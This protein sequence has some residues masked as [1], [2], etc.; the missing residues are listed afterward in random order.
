M[1]K[2]PISRWLAGYVRG[3]AWRVAV[4]RHPM[5]Y[6]N[7]AME[8]VQ[9]FASKADLNVAHCTI[10]EREEYEPHIACGNVIFA[11]VDYAAVLRAAEAEADILVWDGGNND[12]PFIRP[13][14][15]I[16][17][18]DALR[19]NQVATHYPGETVARLADVL[20]VN[21]ANAAHQ[22]DVTA[23][24]AR[25]RAINPGATVVRGN[26][27]IR[28]DDP[29]AISGRRVLVIEDGP[30][31]THGGMA[32]GAGA[33]AALAAGAAELV[34]PRTSAPP[35]LM[36]VF[37][38]YSHIGR[39]LP[40]MG[41]SEAQLRAIGE[42]IE[43]SKA[44]L[45]VASFTPPIACTKPCWFTD[46]VTAKSWRTGTSASAESS[47]YSSADE[48]LSPSTPPYDCSNTRLA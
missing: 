16:G 24:M 35:V 38:E 5:P 33:A 46:P 14:L 11:G 6:G 20:V 8:R 18:V 23:L 42:T 36:A 45:V 10:E 25:L 39:V 27:P 7:L 13:D 17:V 19:P 1:A 40:A 2:S 9:R 41:Y 48:A 32:S 4:I 15:H 37:A 12:F 47:A 31:L 30:T 26:L 22:S 44:E 3:R 28:L 43:H 34:D 21:K 29:A